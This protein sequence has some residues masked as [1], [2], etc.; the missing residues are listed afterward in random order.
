MS[1]NV[2][3]FP[4]EPPISLSIPFDSVEALSGAFD[5]LEVAGELVRR[6]ISSAPSEAAA[7]AAARKVIAAACCVLEPDRQIDPERAAAASSWFTKQVA[8]RHGEEAA[9]AV[10]ARLQAMLEGS[11]AD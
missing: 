4:P 11:A 5:M 7:L 3:H 8:E 6:V 10:A 1:Q 9:R 2:V